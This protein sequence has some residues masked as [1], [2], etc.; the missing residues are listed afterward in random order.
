M[1][2]YNLCMYALGMSKE[3]LIEGAESL[4]GRGM[5]EPSALV[6]LSTP[7]PIKSDPGYLKVL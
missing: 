2:V 4:P 5:H 7:T 3:D 6:V 1:H